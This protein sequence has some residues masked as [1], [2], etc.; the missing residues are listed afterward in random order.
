MSVRPLAYFPHAIALRIW[1]GLCTVAGMEIIS[2]TFR[3][4]SAA[5]MDRCSRSSQQL[6]AGG[7]V[8]TVLPLFVMQSFRG[9]PTGHHKVHRYAK[10]K[11]LPE[12]QIIQTLCVF[13]C[14]PVVNRLC[15]AV[16]AASDSLP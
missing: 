13:L 1:L 5:D 11:K 9:T 3:A 7:T 15:D 6:S 8:D 16:R 14:S 2:F 10:N 4:V 12:I